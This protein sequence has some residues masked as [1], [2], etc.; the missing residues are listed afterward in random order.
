MTED[1]IKERF[2]FHGCAPD[3]V[4]KIC[5]NTLRPSLCD[6]CKSGKQCHDPGLSQCTLSVDRMFRL[7]R[8]PHQRRVS[9]HA[10]YT[11]FYVRYNPAEVGDVGSTIVFKCVTGKRKHFR[12]MVCCLVSAKVSLAVQIKGVPP[13]P[14]FHCHESPNHLEFFIFNPEQVVPVF[15]V[16]WKAIAATRADILHES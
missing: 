13:T 9:K 5:A 11:F 8:R 10:D 12:E 14:G 15:V 7:F 2:V 3:V 4:D 6:M 1:D 16:H